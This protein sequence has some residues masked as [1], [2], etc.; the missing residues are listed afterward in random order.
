[1]D[2]TSKI[3]AS[4][5]ARG[6]LVALLLLA[7]GCAGKPPAP[8]PNALWVL[9]ADMP[10]FD[11]DGPPDPLRWAIE[12]YLSAGLV[13]TDST[14]AVI[15]AAAGAIDVSDDSLVY[16]FRLRPALAFVDGSPCRSGEFARALEAGLARTDHST[17]VWQ[18]AAVRGVDR[19]RAGKPLPVLG[20]E[21]PDDRTLVIRLVKR[22]P[23]FLRKLAIPGTGWPWKRRDVSRWTDAVGLGPDRVMAGDTVRQIV[24]ARAPIAPVRPRSM[25]DTVTMRFQPS[26]V[27]VRSM[28]RTGRPDFVWPV[29]P[30]V[31]SEA[32]PPGYRGVSRPSV[33]A[34]RLALVMRAD[35]PPTTRLATR[36][37]LAHGINRADV[38]R[39]LGTFASDNESWIPGAPPLE[40]P[41]LDPQ[42]I[43]MWRERGKLGRSFHVTM[44]YDAN[45]PAAVAARAM[46][47]EWAGH[48]I[49]VELRP[50]A[51]RALQGELL[52]GVSQLALGE[53]G[54]LVEGP[55][56]VLSTLI[57]P[58]RGPAVGSI[59]SGWRTREFDGWIDPRHAPVIWK[60]AQVQRRLEEERV[61]LPIARLPW[62]WLERVGAAEAPFHPDR[63]PDC[64]LP[65]R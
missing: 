9:G 19:V 26:A 43:E 52:G 54:D 32:L 16:T 4:L 25:P 28:L 37:A 23:L 35:V 36:H 21:A 13:E 42:A 58:F 55:A 22:D 14:G 41:E 30:G 60:P 51:G 11:P 17:R 56:G 7:A 2:G 45:G 33:P 49:Y 10:A 8:K 27:K 34:R 39:A 24:L 3:R 38:L 62:L 63:G 61:V 47:G 31:L 40:F 18:L 53:L 50:L 5:L 59:R 57:M 64:P 15:P 12:R 1:M 29:P 48:A 44:A 6:V 20:I 65:A 46:Q